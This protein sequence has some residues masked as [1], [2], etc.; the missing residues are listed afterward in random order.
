MKTPKS[1]RITLVAAAIAAV[2]LASCASAPVEPEGAA[3]LRARLIQLQSDPQLGNR[4]PLAMQQAAAAVTAAE[5]P[6]TD[7]TVSDYRLFMAD[8]KI[9][10]AQADA[11]SQLAIDQRKGLQEQREALRLQERT[12]EADA[13]N[14]RANA[15]QANA[16]NQTVL[17]QAAN[18]RALAAQADASDQAQQADAARADAASQTQQAD[19][20]RADAASQAQQADAAR[21]AAAEL[22]QQINGLQA[23]VTDRGL[24][25]TLGDVLFT[26]GSANLNAGGD[27]HLAKLAQF[28]NKYSNRTALIEGHTDNVGGQDYNLG[29]SQRRAD[30]VKAYL[31]NQGIDASRLSA[32]GKGKDSPIADNSTAIGRQENR[33]VEVIIQNKQVSSR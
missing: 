22:Q 29:L 1:D 30:A 3:A 24:V 25:L 12:Q 27:S 32:T 7:K 28:L 10:I 2:L 5:Q 26:S 20:A 14:R 21:A 13:A 18:S 16:M 31:V 11:Q 17:A 19:A 23:R 33:R 8:R 9:S 15:A 6:E 4:A